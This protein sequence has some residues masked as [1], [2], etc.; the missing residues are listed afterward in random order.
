MAGMGCYPFHAPVRAAPGIFAYRIIIQPVEG[1]PLHIVLRVARR[2][3]FNI[4]KVEERFLIFST[5]IPDQVVHVVQVSFRTG[6]IQM[7]GHINKF[8]V[9]ILH[10]QVIHSVQI[11]I[12]A[13]RIVIADA[14][15]P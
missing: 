7:S 5:I 11:G 4:G 9:R 14:S 1:A 12:N 15:A 6:A 8:Y 10:F 3:T 2:I 13:G